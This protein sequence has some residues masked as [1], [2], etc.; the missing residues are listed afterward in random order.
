MEISDPTRQKVEGFLHYGADNSQTQGSVQIDATGWHAYAV[1]WAP[2]TITYFVDGTP[3]F[4]DDD[5]SHNPP[6][7]M[8]LTIQLDYFGGDASG[9]AQMHVDWVRQ[10]ELTGSGTG[11][12]AGVDVSAGQGGV[13]AG[14][15]VSLGNNSGGGDRSGSTGERSRDRTGSG[16]SGGGSRDGN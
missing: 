1:E 9:G 4:T 15:G 11:V 12:G 13:D 7:P 8:H 3:W 5:K 10:Y 6:G 16:D 2:D 14:A